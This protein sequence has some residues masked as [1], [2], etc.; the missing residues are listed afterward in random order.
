MY[1]FMIAIWNVVVYVVLCSMLYI[2]L[3]WYS[4]WK[5]DDSVAN[6]NNSWLIFIEQLFQCGI[7][8]WWN[9][10]WSC[11]CGTLCHG[12]EVLPVPTCRQRAIQCHGPV[13]GSPRSQAGD[14]YLDIWCYHCIFVFSVYCEIIVKSLP[15]TCHNFFI[16][17]LLACLK[18]C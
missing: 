3:L 11:G 10:C 13:S 16:Q 7:V 8:L 5:H 17:P 15:F 9:H 4:C 12:L 1:R 14:N 6:D 2:L 18:C